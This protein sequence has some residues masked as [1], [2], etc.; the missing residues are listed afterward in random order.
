MPSRPETNFSVAYDS[1]LVAES[2]LLGSS[3]IPFTPRLN[4]VML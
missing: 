2:G 1:D 3:S 4:S